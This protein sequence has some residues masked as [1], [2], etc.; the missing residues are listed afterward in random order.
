MATARRSRAGA[1]KAAAK[2]TTRNVTPAGADEMPR[3][4]MTIASGDAA[5]MRSAEMPGGSMASGMTGGF[6]MSE[7]A[8]GDMNAGMGET[9]GM[10]EMPAGGVS[11]GGMDSGGAA[12]G[13]ID[14]PGLWRITLTPV[15]GK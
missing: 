13:A 15:S 1:T 14:L 9:P 7:M 6:G 8:S 2:S 11:S 10:G 4:E 3:G 12:V 5:G